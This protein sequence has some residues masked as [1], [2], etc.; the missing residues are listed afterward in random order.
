MSFFYGLNEEIVVLIQTLM[1]IN[2]YFIEQQCSDFVFKFKREISNALVGLDLGY[3]KLFSI[4]HIEKIALFFVFERR[5][6]VFHSLDLNPSG[7]SW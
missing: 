6:M 7:V 1:K 2:L 5:K 4:F 3:E